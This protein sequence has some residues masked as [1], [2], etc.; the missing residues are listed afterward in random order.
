MKIFMLGDSPLI[1]TGFGVVGAVAMEALLGAGHELIILG[2]QDNREVDEVKGLPPNVT[3]IPMHKKLGGDL[4]GWA[5][6]PSVA[7]EFKPDAVNIVG[8]CAMVATW[9]LHPEMKEVPVHAYMPIE[10][11]PL[12][13]IWV[14]SFI[15]NPNLHITTCTHYG[16]E[17]L[18]KV[19]IDAEFAYHGVSSDFY[20]MLPEQRDEIRFMV[21]WTDRFVVMCVAQNVRRKQ[22]PRLMQAIALLKK[23][24]PNILLYAHTVP[25]NNFW[26]DG[27]DLTQ[28]ADN[29]GIID[30]IVFN[31]KH[32]VHNASIP[33][34]GDGQIPGLAELYNAADCFMLP[35][36]VEGFGL[37]LA[38][39][40][41]SGLP[42]I[43]TNHA[44]Q[45][46]V[47]GKAGVLIDPHD[48]E[49]NKSSAIYGNLDPADI[50]REI[51]RLI[52]SP[53]LRKQYARKGIERAKDFRWDDYKKV[54][55]DFYG[56]LPVETEKETVA[57]V[58]SFNQD[59]DGKP[60]E[61]IVIE[62]PVKS[63]D[64]IDS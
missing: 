4:L 63:G 11:A 64:G 32:T 53:E 23:R 21:N 43:T 12:N 15:E 2:G 27:H 61:A 9:M 49:I 46:E 51:E 22:W 59:I 16:V 57:Q 58:D 10:G 48:W 56:S 52:K 42:V 50:A 38:E 33:V 26:L 19:G 30:N 41:A 1:H 17:E 29:L 39:A 25:F 18:R 24:Y 37:P 36:Q 44:A 31:P 34:K 62:G 35:S 3:Y 47:V 45:A 20:P 14:R 54:L 6:A 8:D 55:V 40:M 13:K 5:L 60:R 7:K 28:I